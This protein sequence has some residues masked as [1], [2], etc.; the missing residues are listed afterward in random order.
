MIINLFKKKYQNFIN[1]SY[2]KFF[3]LGF[4]LILNLLFF[5]IQAHAQ[6]TNNNIAYKVPQ[7]N[8]QPSQIAPKP[9]Y[10]PIAPAVKPNN[11]P[12]K[13]QAPSAP[14]PSVQAPSAPTPSQ[15]IPNQPTQ[16]SNNSNAGIEI[17]NLPQNDYFGPKIGKSKAKK[18]V[19][20]KIINQKIVKTDSVNQLDSDLNL[21]KKSTLDKNYKK[22]LQIEQESTQ[23]IIKNDNRLKYNNEIEQE[24]TQKIIKNDNRLKYND[25]IE[26]KKYYINTENYNFKDEKNAKWLSYEPDNAVQEKFIITDKNSVEDDFIKKYNNDNPIDNF[27]NDENQNLNSIK[28]P[29]KTLKKVNNHQI[30]LA[31]ENLNGK[32]VFNKYSDSKNSEKTK[33][34]INNLLLSKIELENHFFD[35]IFRTNLSFA[36][37]L[38]SAKKSK[39]TKISIN[40]S[41]QISAKDFST[42]SNNFKELNFLSSFQIFKDYLRFNLGYT[43]NN[44]KFDESKYLEITSSDSQTENLLNTNNPKN[45]AVK[46]NNFNVKSK[47]PFIGIELKVPVIPNFTSLKIST[48]YSNKASINNKIFSRTDNKLLKTSFKN[49]KFFNL[50]I[51]LENKITQNLTLNLNYNFQRIN[52]IKSKIEN[53]DD[54]KLNYG[55]SSKFSTFGVNLGYNF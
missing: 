13:V 11:I 41:D 33:N 8:A 23:K 45:P 16:P 35:R 24:S 53:I 30:K 9:N 14:T 18:R 25:E 27:N 36:G 26:S 17:K 55:L 20:K 5:N 3:I 21:E 7:P 32:F 46:N 2:I 34:K 39:Y 22:S 44:L 15:A 42:S 4:F 6:S 54:K 43:Y 19:I 51:E 12:T 1:F 38:N 29:S 50:G 40:D 37:S 10:A 28:T 49:A 52:L 48:N 31:V 47:I